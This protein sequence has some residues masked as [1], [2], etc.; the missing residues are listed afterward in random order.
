MVED[1]ESDTFEVID[2]LKNFTQEVA[3]IM[4]KIHATNIY[5]AS[6]DERAD[7][8]NEL[9]LKPNDNFAK[10][11]FQDLRN[12]IKIKTVYEVNFDSDELIT[13]SIENINNNLEIRKVKIIISG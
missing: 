1:I 9:I 4:M 11:E 12:K 2:S 8:V 3:N 10:K 13:N 7:D 5:K 6:T